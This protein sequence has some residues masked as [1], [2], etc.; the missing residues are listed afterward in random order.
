LKACLPDFS[1]DDF[2]LPWAGFLPASDCRVEPAHWSFPQPNHE[3]ASPE[4]RNGL[5]AGGKAKAQG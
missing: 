5:A 2:R 4:L 1:P 3:P